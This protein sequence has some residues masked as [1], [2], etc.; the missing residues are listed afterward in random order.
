MANSLDPGYKSIIY[1]MSGSRGRYG[2][3]VNARQI[4]AT[5]GAA[6][7]VT[8]IAAANANRIYLLIQCTDAAVAA[9]IYMGNELIGYLYPGDWIMWDRDHPWTGA[10]YA[11]GLTGDTAIRGVEVELSAEESR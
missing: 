4:T 5:V 11:I 1:S 9:Q 3:G 6:I 7:P 2:H 10:V 8:L